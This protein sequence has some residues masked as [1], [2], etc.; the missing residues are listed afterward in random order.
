MDKKEREERS[1]RLVALIEELSKSQEIFSNKKVLNDY[2][3]KL[4]GIYKTKTGDY[5]RHFYNDIFST[6]LTK[7]VIDMIK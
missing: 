5:F 7:I 1:K 4:G 2:Y 3:T 6:I